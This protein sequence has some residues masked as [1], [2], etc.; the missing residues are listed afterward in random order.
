MTTMSAEQFELLPADRAADDLERELLER[1]ESEELFRQTLEKNASGKPWVFFE[2][3]PTANGK[4][5]IHHVF[6]RTIK[7]LFCRHRAM[8]G[9]RVDRKAGWDTHGL[10]VEIE[11][12]KQLGI[13]G[14]QQ[15]EALGVSE[16]NRLC[17]ESVFRYR[18]DWEKLSARIGYWL[19]YEHPYVTYTNDYVESVWW[20]LK[21]LHDK[22]L[23]YRGHKILPYCARCGTALSSHELALG[24][25]DVEGPSVYVALP[26]EDDSGRKRQF[27][28][29]TT[30]PWTLVSNVALAVHPELDYVEV[31]RR[32]GADTRTLILAESRLKAVLGDDFADR[33]NIVARVKG[34][35][36]VGMRYKRPFEWLEYPEGHHEIVVGEEFVSA[37]D[38]SGIVHMAPAFGADDYAAGRKHDLAFLQ[39]VDARGQFP[40]DMP[41]VAGKFVLDADAALTEE[42][43]RRGLLYRAAKHMHSY[44]HCWRCGTPLIY[45]ARTSWFVKTS[46]YKDGMLARNARIDWHPPEVGAGRFG[47]WL[48]NNIDWAISR[49]RYWGTPLPVWICDADDTHVDVV[50]S[51]ADLAGRNGSALPHDFDPHKPHVDGYSWNC[52]RKGC[53]GT[54]RRTAEVIDTWFDSGSMSFAQWHYPFENKERF[55]DQFP[56]DFIAEGVD[57][58]RGW[59]YSL[60]AIA[61]GLGESLAPGKHDGSSAAPP[62]KAVVVNDLLLDKDGKKMSKSVGNVVD[63]QEMIE[64]YGVDTVRLFFVA[65]SDVS[66]PRR[67][68]EKVIRELAGR[69][70]LTLKN[71]YSGSFAQYANFGWKP[72]MQQPRLQPIDRWLLGRLAKVQ[73]EA[74]QALERFDATTAARLIMTFVDEDLSKWYVRLTRDRRYEVESEDANAAFYTLHE[75]LVAVC[76]LLAPFSP[77]LPDWMHRQLTGSSVHLAPYVEGRH[78]IEHGLDRAMDAIRELARLGRAAREVAGINVRQPLPRLVCVAPSVSARD[79]DALIPLLRDELNVKLVEVATS[80]DALVTLEAKPNF[81]SLGKRFG[82][83]TPLAAAAVQAF[84]G[85][86]LLRFEHGEELIVTVDGESHAL[87]PED[88]T[89]LRRSVGDL[90]VQEAAGFFAAIDTTISPELRSE[91]LARELISR[92]QRMRKESGF[93]ISDRIGLLIGGDRG[94]LEAVKTHQEWIKGEV[95]A[96]ELVVADAT[97]KEQPDMTQID[98]D[99][100]VARLSITRIS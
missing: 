79:F 8:R 37:D 89:I 18:S 56:A 38:G 26:V 39:P 52:S 25:K 71:V 91:G 99:G 46:S 62:Y 47:S 20:A 53:A 55:A 100:I 63:P 97:A 92:V 44:P 4:P 13:S 17:R 81:R 24:Y 36:L 76:R 5:G 57:Q 72:T 22:E 6:A 77:F 9:Y 90:V 11:V 29:W 30:T 84:S 12:E 10:P 88:V 15:I 31:T 82:K 65:S 75:A 73:Q 48:E 2:G 27:L 42:L 78:S 43:K 66:V 67:F 7:D 51:Y 45:Y 94:I 34:A 40:S 35:M 19:D 33:W 64:K 83:K 21:T 50:G 87:V 95:L 14:K 69:F 74:D 28:V 61:T 93:A 32:S 59:F 80:A 86:D 41:L 60:L 68:D 98:L 96:T 1:W 16:F 3:P 23:L 70:L 49:D 58:T 85:A 54:M